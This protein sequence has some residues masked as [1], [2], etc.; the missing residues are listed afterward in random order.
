VP[1]I[2]NKAQKILK[3]SKAMGLSETIIKKM[4]N[5]LTAKDVK[6]ITNLSK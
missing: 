4:K 6:M 1:K 2:Q 5:I 3:V